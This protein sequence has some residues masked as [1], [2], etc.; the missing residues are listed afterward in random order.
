MLLSTFF[1]L[2]FPFGEVG[3][4]ALTSAQNPS[5]NQEI[6]RTRIAILAHFVSPFHIYCKGRIHSSYIYTLLRDR[7]IPKGVFILKVNSRI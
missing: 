6:I 3:K 1:C 7:S 5:A 2:T 4:A